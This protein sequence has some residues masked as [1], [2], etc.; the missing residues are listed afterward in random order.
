MIEDLTIAVPEGGLQPVT[1]LHGMPVPVEE[2]KENIRASAKFNLPLLER[3][4]EP[5][6]GS[7]IFVA[8]GTSLTSHLDEI[9]E[10]K[11]NGELIATSNNTHDFLVDNGIIP[12]ICSMVDPKERCKDYIKKPQKETRY[13]IAVVCNPS[14]F[15]NLI[16]AGAKVEKLL[17]GYGLD[18]DE[19]VTMQMELYA[20]NKAMSFLTGGT[21]MGLRA[22][23]LAE[24]LGY[25]KI[26]YYGMDSC[27]SNESPE[28]IMEDD[29]RFK[30]TVKRVGNK[31]YKDVSTGKKYVYDENLD[32][33]FF[34][35]YKKDRGEDIQIA[36]TS[37]GRRFLTSHVL[38]H[39]AKQFVKW[40]DRLEGKIEVVTHGDS[41]N[42]HMY[43]L[44]QEAK[45]KAFATIGDKRW[46][47][48]H[49]A[50]QKTQKMLDASGQRVL[51]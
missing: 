27:F 44:H 29:P 14:V 11:K 16:D 46:T 20:P 18:D 22:M 34:Y 3:Y 30:D 43:K 31:F 1:D 51:I 21:M 37:D 35:A 38:A 17:V 6:E 10:R 48:R 26:E 8:G 47:K 50:D 36:E 45:A 19:D 49:I 39:Q 12:D 32:G 42:S 28:L 4:T 33:G 9:R 40:T 2:V 41:L 5:Q 7:Y 15:Q 13:I 23:N 25:K 24:L